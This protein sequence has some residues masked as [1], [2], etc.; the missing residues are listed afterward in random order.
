MKRLEYFA[1]IV[2]Q[3]LELYAYPNLFLWTG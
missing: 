3:H 1:L 2:F